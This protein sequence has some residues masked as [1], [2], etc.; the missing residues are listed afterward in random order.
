MH[1]YKELEDPLNY[2]V[3]LK[4]KKLGI[5][6]HCIKQR[7]YIHETNHTLFKLENI[8]QFSSVK[9]C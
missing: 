1:I 2:F 9:Y 5:G 6:T 8:F 7:L 3:A 4:K